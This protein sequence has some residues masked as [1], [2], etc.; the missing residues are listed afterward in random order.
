M[1]VKVGDTVNTEWRRTWYEHSV[2]G[3]LRSC[4]SNID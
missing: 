3:A 4:C 2:D 1:E